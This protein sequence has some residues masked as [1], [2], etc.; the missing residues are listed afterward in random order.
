MGPQQPG[1]LTSHS[2]VLSPKGPSLTLHEQAASPGSA[3]WR[4]DSA[5]DAS[6]FPTTLSTSLPP[7]IVSLDVCMQDVILSTFT[8][9]LSAVVTASESVL[10]VFCV[11]QELVSF[12]LQYQPMTAPHCVSASP[13]FS[14][15]SHG[16]SLW[17]LW[18]PL[19]WQHPHPHPHSQAH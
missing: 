11:P 9:L 10:T 2:W 1:L 6:P 15:L 16:L 4:H 19:S 13:A 3:Q 5:S 18:T 17:G 8:G 12:T 14:W 7:W